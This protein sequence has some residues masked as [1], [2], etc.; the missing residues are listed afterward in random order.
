MNIIDVVIIL[1]LLMGAVIGFK[2]GLTGSLVN[3]VGLILVLVLAYILKNPVSALMYKFL[4][5]F[6]F[7]GVIKGVTVLNIALYE[8][9]AFLLVASVLIA[10]LKLVIFASSLFEKILAFT[11]IL[12]IP[13][14]ILGAVIGVVQHFIIIFIVLYL[15]NLPF[16]NIDII[17]QSKYK[18]KILNSTP[19]LSNMVSGTL[20]V[21]K[22]FSYLKYKYEFGE[23]TVEQF[24]EDY[25]EY[26]VVNDPNQFNLETLDLFLKHKVITV[27]AAKGL[28]D[29]NKLNIPGADSVLGKYE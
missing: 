9:I 26:E 20:D 14:K 4:P 16:F 23:K 6:S 27:D 15:F 25:P 28:I 17:N 13:S 24:L 19:I 12:G 7:G 8:F 18:D 1:V 5:F 10:I 2:R 11:I 21:I 3:F 22:E 29:S